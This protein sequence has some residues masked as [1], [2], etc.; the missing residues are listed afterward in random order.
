M[1][2]NVWNIFGLLLN[3]QQICPCRRFRFYHIRSFELMKL[4]VQDTYIPESHW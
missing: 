3:H 2:K 1:P 4:K